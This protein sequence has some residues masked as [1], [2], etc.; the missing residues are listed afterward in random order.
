MKRYELIHETFNK[1]AGDRSASTEIT[2][3][4]T[5]DVEAWL[6]A[7]LHGEAASLERFETNGGAII[8]EVEIAG[9]KERYSFSEA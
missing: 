5:D 1:C 3:I 9:L 2:T 7:S 6:T 8:Y 4:E